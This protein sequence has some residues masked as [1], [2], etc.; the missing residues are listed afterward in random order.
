[1]IEPLENILLHKDYSQA[2]QILESILFDFEVH[3]WFNPEHG[4]I[5]VTN[6]M[7]RLSNCIIEIALNHDM[8]PELLK[9][10]TIYHRMIESIF[11]L[12]VYNNA[13]H[14]TTHLIKTDPVKALLLYTLNSKYDLPWEDLLS[15]PNNF[16]FDIVMGLVSNQTVLDTR[17]LEVKNKILSLKQMAPQNVTEDNINLVCSAYAHVSYGTLDHKE[18]FKRHINAQLQQEPMVLNPKSGKIVVF[19]EQMNSVHAMYRC[20]GTALRYLVNNSKTTIVAPKGVLDEPIRKW[21]PKL[22]EV[23]SLDMQVLKDRIVELQPQLIWYPSV[24]LTSATML[25]ANTRLAPIQVV[26]LGHP[27]ST[28][29]EFIDYAIIPKYSHREGMQDYFTE[30]LLLINDAGLVMT[31][32][33][34]DVDY[35]VVNQEE[36]FIVNIAIPAKSY[37]LSPQYLDTLQA[38]NDY[39]VKLHFFPNE[40]GIRQEL[41]AS[42]I[43]ARFS[44]YSNARVYLRDTYQPYIDNLSK[45]HIYAATFPF[46]GS[47]SIYDA[48]K[49]GLIPVCLANPTVLNENTDAMLLQYLGLPDELIT[50]THEEYQNKIIE[51]V[52]NTPKRVALQKQC[53][54]AINHMYPS[55]PSILCNTFKDL[56]KKSLDKSK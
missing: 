45:C 29:S 12:S 56:M 4:N 51:L 32:P 7:T 24:G 54:E 47:N 1:M 39:Q 13:D 37:K 14:I 5:N 25:L 22:I 23:E 46:G 55:N 11:K 16:A 17:S 6:I 34:G 31:P 52:H 53:L 33:V 36:A 35:H 15:A 2:L 28:Q 27:E 40:Q 9:V 19:I 20:F 48:L 3:K 43:E 8:G 21:I 18:R 41:V 49:C 38:I 50:H 44:R 30:K 42:E 10:Y 26:T